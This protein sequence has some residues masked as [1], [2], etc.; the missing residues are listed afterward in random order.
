MFM[1]ERCN[2]SAIHQL[3]ALDYW[4]IV[5]KC[6]STET[7]TDRL[8][9]VGCNKGRKLVL[10]LLCML[11]LGIPGPALYQGHSRLFQGGVVVC[12]YCM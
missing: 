4:W 1:P 9:D 3:M 11:F 6:S 5:L 2:Q 8:D 10:I 7:A 12:T